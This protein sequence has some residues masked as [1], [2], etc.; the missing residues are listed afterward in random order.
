MLKWHKKWEHYGDHYYLSLVRDEALNMELRFH[1][2]SK[3][4]ALKNAKEYIDSL[5][6]FSKR[7]K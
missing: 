6:E 1:G 2:L 5:K 7:L 4:E 3:A